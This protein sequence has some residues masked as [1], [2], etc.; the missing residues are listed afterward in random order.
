[1]VDI[2]RSFK[3]KVFGIIGYQIKNIQTLGGGGILIKIYT[4]W[5][6]PKD[7]PL[8]L[9]HTCTIFDRRGIPITVKWY[10]FHVPTVYSQ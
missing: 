4:E 3:E 6:H 8:T 5:L 1:M 10:T 2:V 7:Q 9:L